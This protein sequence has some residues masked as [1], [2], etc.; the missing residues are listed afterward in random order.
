MISR[1][2]LQCLSFPRR[3]A[4]LSILTALQAA[5]AG[6]LAQPEQPGLPKCDSQASMFATLGTHS[7]RRCCS[8]RTA[9]RTPASSIQT[10]VVNY[11]PDV[12]LTIKDREAILSVLIEGNAG[13]AQSRAVLEEHVGRDDMDASVVEARRGLPPSGLPAPRTRRSHRVLEPIL[14]LRRGRQRTTTEASS[15]A[16]LDP[17]I[18][19]VRLRSAMNRSHA[20]LRS[21]RKHGIGHRRIPERRH[22]G[23]IR[24]DPG[25]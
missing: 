3:G 10:A 9:T 14:I 7:A 24:R 20:F 18:F 2:R 11:E 23:L 13:L 4:P 5:A 6:H 19:S 12:V 8:D 22:M 25:R 21:V 1:L 16:Y 15:F 17:A